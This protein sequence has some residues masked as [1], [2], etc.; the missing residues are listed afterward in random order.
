MFGRGVILAGAALQVAILAGCGG[1]GG[2]ETVTEP[3]A[4]FLK[5]VNAICAKSPAR[6]RKRLQV[7]GE[8][9]SD[10]PL[11][12]Q[13]QEEVIRK[14]QLGPVETVI[15]ELGSLRPPA[16]AEDRFEAFVAALEEEI[17]VGQAD[18]FKATAGKLFVK[19]DRIARASGMAACEN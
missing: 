3:R 11:T 7:A 10:A 17:G 18:P 9:K 16:E 13:E 15:T 5:Q 12:R 8:E 14:V 4:A 19:S 6:S 1:G 2:G